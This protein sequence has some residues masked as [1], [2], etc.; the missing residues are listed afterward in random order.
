MKLIDTP[1]ESNSVNTI[2]S[3]LLLIIN[4]S[5]VSFKRIARGSFVDLKATLWHCLFLQTFDYIFEK[6]TLGRRSDPTLAIHTIYI[7]VSNTG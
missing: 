5:T 1:S 3:R 7:S 2:T 4:K 6:K